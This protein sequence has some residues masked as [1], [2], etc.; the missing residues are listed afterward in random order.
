MNAVFIA[1]L[2]ASNR[3]SAVIDPLCDLLGPKGLYMA[4]HR[5]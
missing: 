5:S 2:F 4:V 3:H 1:R